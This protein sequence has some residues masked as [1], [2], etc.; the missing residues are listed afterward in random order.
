[1]Y[2]IVWPFLLFFFFAFLCVLCDLR[3]LHLDESEKLVR[4]REGDLLIS[5][6][7]GR[8]IDV[9]EVFVLHVARGRERDEDLVVGG[10][11]GVVGFALRGEPGLDGVDAVSRGKASAGCQ[12]A[13]VV[14]RGI[15]VR[16]ADF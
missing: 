8:L 1:M 2:W 11:G 7:Q 9:D 6:L 12:E 16:D 5:R 10:A 3:A 13:R 15:E 4:R 14:A